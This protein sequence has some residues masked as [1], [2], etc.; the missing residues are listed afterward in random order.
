MT[1]YRE[2]PDAGTPSAIALVG[3][4]VI[5]PGQLIVGPFAA[6]TLGESGVDVIKMEPPERSSQRDGDSLRCRHLLRNDRSLWC[7]PKSRNKRFVAID[8]ITP[9]GQKIIRRFV[10]AGRIYTAADVDNTVLVP[11]I[12]GAERALKR[13][14]D[15]VS[16]V[17]SIF[18]TR[19]TSFVKKIH[20]FV[21]QTTF[22]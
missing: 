21:A 6:K 19:N 7:E 12:R 9:K 5:E 8:L 1:A 13:A 10:V 18:E 4:K 3:L 16:G 20:G 14:V 22:L 2:L 17:M 15:D 11:K